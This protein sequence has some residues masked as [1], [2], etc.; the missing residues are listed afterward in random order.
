MVIFKGTSINS[1]IA[2]GTLLHYNRDKQRINKYK[3][4]DTDC[5]I[6][7]FNKARNK[8]IDKLMN[9]NTSEIFSVYA[10]L[11]EDYDIVSAIEDTIQNECV[12]AE[13]AVMCVIEKFKLMFA[14]M[15]DYM[16]QRESDFIDAFSY[17]TSELMCKDNNITLNKPVIVVA[18]DIYPSEFANMDKTKVLG[19]VT[20]QGSSSSHLS[21]LARGSNIPYIVCT[22]LTS[23]NELNNK[24]GVIDGEDGVFY[25]EPNN[26]TIVQFTEKLNKKANYQHSLKSLKDSPTITKDGKSIHLYANINSMDELSLA[27]DN[28]C[29]GIGLVRSELLY[30]NNTHLP[31]E[32][33]QFEVYKAMA[34]KM[35]DKRLIIRTLDV[36]SDKQLSYLPLP[37]EE[38]PALGYRAIR[39]SLDRTDIFK[40]QLRAIYRASK[41]GRVAVM[42]PMVTTLEEIIEVKNII[43]CVKQELISENIA[44]ND[45]EIGV[46]VET[47][48]SVIISDLLAKEVDFISIGTNDLVQYTFAVDRASNKPTQ[49]REDSNY[50]VIT[51]MLKMVIE[52]AH[53]EGKWVGLCGELG[54]DIDLIKFLMKEGLDEISVSPSSILEIRK[55]IGEMCL[56]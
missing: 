22:N 42:F 43:K 2:L 24:Y 30:M 5:E 54:N 15:D 47:P 29:E 37:K 20:K 16:K 40:S 45:I 49:L 32:Q 52:N 46:M 12:N 7:R 18:E 39:I 1:D 26:E 41:F 13:Y 25:I 17:I 8:A 3:V 48:S 10:M 56:Y 19:I 33:E 31:T 27:I 51:R 11:L 38:N 34:E 6:I 14:D 44:F 23:L 55:K 50:M 53:N 21:V 36:S 9:M 28:G 35:K 4:E